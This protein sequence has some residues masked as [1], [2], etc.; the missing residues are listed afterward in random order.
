[1]LREEIAEA[2]LFR[3]PFFSQFP[4]QWSTTPLK[5]R[6]GRVSDQIPNR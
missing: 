5:E 6:A 3:T 1:M 4:P 2:S